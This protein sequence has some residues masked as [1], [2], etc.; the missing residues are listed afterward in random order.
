MFGSKI[1]ILSLFVSKIEIILSNSIFY[2]F[3]QF[4]VFDFR[5]RG[6][7]LIKILLDEKADIVCLQ[8]VTPRFL[9]LLLGS[10]RAFQH[11]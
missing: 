8:E 1:F 10:K 6:K 5:A 2:F 4:S 11:F 3:H 9:V 7:A